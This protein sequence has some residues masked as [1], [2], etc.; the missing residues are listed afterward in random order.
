MVAARQRA[1]QVAEL[2]GLEGQDQV[3]FATAVSEMARNAVRY[4][5]GGRIEFDVDGAPGAQAL[6][7]RVTDAGPGIPHLDEVLDGALRVRNGDGD[8]ARGHAP[9]DGPLRAAHRARRGDDASTLAK[10][11][12]RRRR[13]VDAA[14]ARAGGRGAGAAAARRTPWRSCSGRTRSWW[15]PSPEVRTRQEELARLNQELEDTNRGVVALYA[16]LDERVEQL[17]RANALRAA[18]HVVHEPRVPHARWTASWP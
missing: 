1:R 16:E 11:L 13:S 4:A 10:R 8:G 14:D 15:R 9:A 5:G 7:A 2:L 6:V 12:P 18:V 3:R 17:R